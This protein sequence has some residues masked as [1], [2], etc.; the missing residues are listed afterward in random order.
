[1]ATAIELGE[2][3]YPKKWPEVE[4]DP[5]QGKSLVPIFKGE[6]REG[7]EFLYFRFSTNRAILKDDWKLVTHKASQWGAI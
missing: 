3:K 4:V 6:E 1:M 5:L 2:A 7:H